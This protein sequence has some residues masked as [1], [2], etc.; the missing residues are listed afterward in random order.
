MEWGEFKVLFA[1]KH[2]E[3]QAVTRRSRAIED[4]RERRATWRSIGNRLMCFL[5]AFVTRG[6]P[7]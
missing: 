7:R 6:T 4:A 2:R 5:Q 1:Q 3:A